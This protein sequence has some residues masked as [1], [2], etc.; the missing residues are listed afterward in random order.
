MFSITGSSSYLDFCQYSLVSPKG[1]NILGGLGVRAYASDDSRCCATQV[2]SG[3]S[4]LPFL[5]VP[6]ASSKLASVR[7]AQL[8]AYLTGHEINQVLPGVRHPSSLC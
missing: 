2:E 4:S 1:S 3:I 8:V 7:E 6:R 5:C